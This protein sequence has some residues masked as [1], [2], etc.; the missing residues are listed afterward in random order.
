MYQQ[1]H[2]DLYAGIRA[3]TPI[4]D[5]VWMSHST[6]LGIMARMS[7]YTGR[8]IT[9]EEAL[10][11]EERLAPETWQLGAAEARPMAIPGET[12]FV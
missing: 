4:N 1:E 8:V 6:M 12:P 7:A 2:D 11:S 5:G 10:S 9:W 3:G